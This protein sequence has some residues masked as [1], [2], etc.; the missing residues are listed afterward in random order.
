VLAF[1]QLRFF[2]GVLQAAM[3]AY[4]MYGAGLTPAIL[5]AF[6]WKRATPAG[7]VAS[8]A[9]GML[10][11]LGWELGGGQAIGATVYPA[12]AT[13]V[14]LLVGVSLLGRPPAAERWRRFFEGSSGVGTV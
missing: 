9:G 10:V 12:L 3:Y 2:S 11:T 14:V 8:I 4:T 1:A 13:S 5:A 7:G 6:F